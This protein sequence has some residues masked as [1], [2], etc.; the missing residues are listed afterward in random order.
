MPASSSI[1]SARAVATASWPIRVQSDPDIP[2][3]VSATCGHDD[4]FA[5]DNRA[6]DAP[7]RFDGSKS[8]TSSLS[9]W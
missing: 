6:W 1:S 9:H 3:K 4:R 5:L 2:S 7:L 8:K